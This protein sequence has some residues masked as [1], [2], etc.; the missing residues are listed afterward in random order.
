MGGPQCPLSLFF[1]CR[2]Q[3]GPMSPVEFKKR[4]CHPVEFEG[5]GPSN[6]E[7][8]T[9]FRVDTNRRREGRGERS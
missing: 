6:D 7:K 4:S 1:F 5:Q 9:G 3:K 8:V 2:F